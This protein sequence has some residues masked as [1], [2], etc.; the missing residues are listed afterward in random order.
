MRRALLTA[1]AVVIATAAFGQPPPGDRAGAVQQAQIRAGA[2]YRELEQAQYDR[3]LA[4]QNYI[5]T[6]D[7]YRAA[8]QA[9]EHIKR[10]LDK[11]K[12]ALDAARIDEARARKGYEAALDAVEKAW[13]RPPRR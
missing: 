5:N 2:T 13:G 11:T 9:A 7:A 12:A 1:L 8:L 3:K 10:E 6:Q 4:E